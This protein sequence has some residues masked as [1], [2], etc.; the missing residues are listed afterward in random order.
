MAIIMAVP[1]WAGSANK[2]IQA[3]LSTNG[4]TAAT[5]EI[6]DV[7]TFQLDVAA[8]SSSYPKIYVVP[9]ASAVSF[10]DNRPVEVAAGGKFLTGITGLK[11][12]GK[13]KRTG[14]ASK[15]DS[16]T[17]TSTDLGIDFGQPGNY[18]ISVQVWDDE[19]ILG[20]SNAVDLRVYDVKTVFMTYNAN[21]WPNIYEN[22]L[23]YP[24]TDT[25]PAH[26]LVNAVV[27]GA[28]TRIKVV[29][30]L[31]PTSSP[32]DLLYVP[33][34]GVFC[35]TFNED[36]YVVKFRT[37][38]GIIE[39]FGINPPTD[40]RITL[41]L[42]SLHAKDQEYTF[43]A[44]AEIWQRTAVYD[45]NTFAYRV[46]PVPITVAQIGAIPTI[47]QW[48]SAY[49]LE[50][51]DA[52]EIAAL[53]INSPSTYMAPAAPAWLPSLKQFQIGRGP[54]DE[55][56]G[57]AINYHYFQ[58]EAR[59][60]VKYPLVIWLHGSNG[61]TF[62]W[63]PFFFGSDN[64]AKFATEDY[65]SQFAA[66]GAYVLVPRSN[67]DYGPSHDRRLR[68]DDSY[69]GKKNAQVAPFYLALEDF[70][71]RHPDVDTDRIYVGGFSAGGGMTWLVARECPELF[72]A[73]F[74]A[75][76][77]ERTLPDPEDAEELDALS[78]LPV[79]T[80]HANGDT[81]VPLTDKIKEVMGILTAVNGRSRM[82]IL[83][84][85]AH[86]ELIPVQDN[87]IDPASGA[88]YRDAEGNAVPGTLI[89]WLNDQTASGR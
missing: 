22:A 13:D 81:V 56:T 54:M 15:A 63:K 78:A 47:V 1:A 25:E 70:V 43:A 65:Q 7:V 69:H 23:P 10:V 76:A 57:L 36:G 24:A 34:T 55:E 14:K 50:L 53:Y 41:G 60:G 72:A 32:F 83:N 77:P 3:S 48:N 27:D 9:A 33:E 75:A 67:E 37:C 52:G 29:Q 85:T 16:G 89:E 62:S 87:M 5:I 71:A 68:W 44:D 40:N 66:G 38:P 39:G 45:F 12:S 31:T 59:D 8:S 26:F 18:R 86:S 64:I 73:A 6:G 20:V 74:P 42:N 11:A 21:A 51:N 2:F 30:D 28:H 84:S 35:A 79:W 17:F 46:S 19:K 80:V 88:L 49:W 82:T 58:P 4:E 61:G